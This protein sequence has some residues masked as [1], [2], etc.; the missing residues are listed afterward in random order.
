MII[1]S[2]AD[3]AQILMQRNNSEKWAFYMN[4]YF[5]YCKNIFKK[6]EMAKSSDKLVIF[7]GPSP[8]DLGPQSCVSDPLGYETAE[9][10]DDSLSNTALDSNIVYIP[11]ANLFRERITELEQHFPQNSHFALCNG[12]HLTNEAIQVIGTACAKAILNECSNRIHFQ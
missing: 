12:I 6:I 9:I 7:L 2:I 10:F 11:L 4:T 5:M 3:F 8:V 1:K